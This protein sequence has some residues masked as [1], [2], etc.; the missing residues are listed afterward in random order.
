ML[1]CHNAQT[2]NLEGS[3][4]RVELSEKCLT[5]TTLRFSLGSEAF[6]FY[7]SN[8]CLHPSRTLK[9]ER[10]C[11]FSAA[12]VNRGRFCAVAGWPSSHTSF[13]AH[14]PIRG[15]IRASH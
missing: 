5:L 4:V 3:Q 1:L 6:C 2:F 13:K 7:F 12:N 15:G 9:T 11:L 14:L 8:L 10:T